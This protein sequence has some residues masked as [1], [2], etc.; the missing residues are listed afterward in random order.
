MGRGEKY[1][2]L[3]CGSFGLVDIGLF[4]FPFVCYCIIAGGYSPNACLTSQ[5]TLVFY[6]THSLS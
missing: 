2:S 4:F 6:T 1:D 5:G 3:A